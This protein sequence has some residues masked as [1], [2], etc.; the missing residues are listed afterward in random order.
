MVRMGLGIAF[1][2]QDAIAFDILWMAL[3]ILRQ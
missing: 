1:L 2:L 3:R